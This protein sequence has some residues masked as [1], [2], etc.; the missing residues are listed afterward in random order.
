MTRNKAS[1]PERK[2]SDNGEAADLPVGANAPKNGEDA[3]TPNRP[4]AK[5]DP[6]E[7][8]LKD[9][10]TEFGAV[11]EQSTFT[12]RKPKKDEFFTVYPEMRMPCAVRELNSEN[13]SGFYLMTEEI[14]DDLALDPVMGEL[15]S[16]RDLVV[17][18]SWDTREIYLWPLRRLDPN[19]ADD[20][21]NKTA[22]E[23]AVDAMTAW[24]RMVWVKRKMY[25]KHTK[26]KSSKY[27]PPDW[28]KELGDLTIYDL[29]G[30]AFSES[31]INSL[32]HSI[33]KK[34]EG[35]D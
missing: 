16:L 1:V 34:L 22:R 32:D 9:D 21:C 10:R 2:P 13:G 8:R 33:L 19:R 29:V 18:M 24:V 7:F 30:I 15:I 26:A 27:T 25:Y 12:V 20:K 3:A 11:E 28:K 14:A 31:Y 6:R 17:C 23:A 35:D 5:F 4:S